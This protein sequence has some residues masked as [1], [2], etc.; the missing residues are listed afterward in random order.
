MDRHTCRKVI[1]RS[2]Y[3][4]DFTK[5][6]LADLAIDEL[7]AYAIDPSAELCE[8]I[9]FSQYDCSEENLSFIKDTIMDVV[10][11]QVEID[12][13]I[14]N[15][16]EHYTIARLNIVDRAIIRLAVCELLQ[17][18]LANDIVINEALELTKEYSDLGDNLQVKFNN[19]L[20]DNI[21]RKL[22]NE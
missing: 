3:Q 6:S 10:N 15:A 9:D 16:L 7:I 4:I 17:K 22:P 12:Q 5:A 19:R 21:V 1:V 13:I 18:K 11:K 2:L 8:V 14:A 20:L